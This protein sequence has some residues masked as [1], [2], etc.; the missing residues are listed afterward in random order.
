MDE[1]SLDD[2]GAARLRLKAVQERLERYDG[3]NPDK[4]QGDLR[5]A[6]EALAAVEESLKRRGI[7]PRTEAERL[8]A[9]LDQAFPNAR[10][11][12][13]V[14]FE[15]IRY[16]RRFYPATRSNSGKS[17]RTWDATWERLPDGE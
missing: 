13:V 8:A 10:S 11:N 9:V 5:S 14:V 17:V 2:L 1:P 15:G 3:N 7:L 4:Y 16:R 6:R 12:E